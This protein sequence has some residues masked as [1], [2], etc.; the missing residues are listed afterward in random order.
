MSE[1]IRVVFRAKKVNE[2]TWSNY[3]RP[4]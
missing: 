1:T 2:L 3:L 4:R